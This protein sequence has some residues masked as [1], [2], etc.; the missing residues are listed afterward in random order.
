MK[1]KEWNEVLDYVDELEEELN[2]NGYNM[3]FKPYSMYDGRQGINLMLFDNHGNVFKN[4]YSGVHDSIEEY[5][6]FIN[7]YKHKLLSEVE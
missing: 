3:K 6:R 5:K 7:Y 4:Y 2:N 1:L